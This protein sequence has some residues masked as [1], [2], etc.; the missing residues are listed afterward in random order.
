MG[1]GQF[2]LCQNIGLFSLVYFGVWTAWK[3]QVSCQKKTI[4]AGAAELD[5]LLPITLQGQ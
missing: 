2:S 4:S 3:I 5:P 1:R